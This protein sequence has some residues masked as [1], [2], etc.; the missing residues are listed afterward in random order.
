MAELTRQLL[1]APPQ[2]RADDVRRA[3][4]L[5]DEIDPQQNYPFEFIQYRITGRRSAELA[6]DGDDA[7]VLVGEAV[8]PDLRVLIDALSRSVDLP[9][10]GDGDTA[11]DLAARLNVSTKTLA[12]WRKV[13]LRWRWVAGGKRKCII[14]PRRAVELFLAE[15]GD[16]VRRAAQ[17]TQLTDAQRDTL[18]ARAR[19]LAEAADVSMHQVAAHLARRT[20]RAVETLRLMLEHHDRDHPDHP[21]FADRTGPLTATQRSG[22]ARAYRHGERVG[23]LARQ[24]RRTRSTIYRA[25][26]QRQLEVV[27][28]VPVDHFTSPTFDRPDADDVLLQPLEVT[29]LDP[30]ADLRLD[31]LPPALAALYDRPTLSAEDQRRILVRMNYLK[32]KASRIVAEQREAHDVLAERVAAARDCIQRAARWRDQVVAANLHVVLSAARR[33]VIDLPDRSGN[34]LLR[35]LHLGHRILM[36]QVHLHDPARRQTFEAFLSYQLSRAFAQQ[37]SAD[38]ASPRAQPRLD[39]GAVVARLPRRVTRPPA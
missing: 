11:A 21:I 20:G 4:T 22:I 35:L 8:R 6:S 7:A 25:I 19:R 2:R 17:F 9:D 16:R 33:H 39:A 29:W 13:G 28:R 32:H 12:R 24:Y 27:A 15:Q 18:L 37:L 30:P 10:E 5:H 1:F 34:R 38:E 3:E 26:H 31:D 36:R 14:Y 23:D